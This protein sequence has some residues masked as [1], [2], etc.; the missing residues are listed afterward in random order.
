MHFPTGAGRWAKA[1]VGRFTNMDESIKVMILCF[2]V[3]S[4]TLVGPTRG[5]ERTPIYRC[6]ECFVWKSFD[7]DVYLPGVPKRPHDTIFP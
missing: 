5:P 6:F 1:D 7:G 4:L 2:I 3:L